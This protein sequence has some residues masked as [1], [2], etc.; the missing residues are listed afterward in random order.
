SNLAR[1]GGNITGV[2]NMLPDLESKRLELLRE[3][4]PGLKRLAFLGSANDPATRG[5]VREVQEAATRTGMSVEPVLIAGPDE[6]D[7]ALAKIANDKVDAV[8]LQPLF[9]LS[10]RAAASVAEVA[11]RLRIPAIASF[12]HFPRAGGL[13]SYGPPTEFAR[14]AIARYVDRILKGAAAGDLAIEQPTQF[15][16]TIN[17]KTAKMLGLTVPPT[18]LG[19]ADEVID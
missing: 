8:I 9:T 17:L 6:I 7:R 4:M 3:L 12:A 11:G 14:R 5:F 2:S 16:L 1:P 10:P 18:V 13:I 19:R 15:E